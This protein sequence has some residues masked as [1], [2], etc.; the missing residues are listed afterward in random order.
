MANI[1]ADK[2]YNTYKTQANAIKKMEKVLAK[3]D[4]S[5]KEVS[6]FIATNEEGRFFPVVCHLCGRRDHRYLPT[7]GFFL[8]NGISVVN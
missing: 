6:Y 3:L 2:Q 8:D 5:F 4:D 1:F 7:V